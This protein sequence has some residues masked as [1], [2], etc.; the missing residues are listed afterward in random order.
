MTA[1]SSIVAISSMRP[2]QRGQRRTSRSTARRIRAAHVQERGVAAPPR[3]GWAL[4]MAPSGPV[5]GSPSGREEIEGKGALGARFVAVDRERDALV[6]ERQ[7]RQ[8]APA[9]ELDGRER[10]D[11]LDDVGVVRAGRAV[12]LEHFVEEALR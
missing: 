6:A 4:S 10:L 1:G 7:V 12:G 2:G 8:G 9:A 5:A 11:A 3:S